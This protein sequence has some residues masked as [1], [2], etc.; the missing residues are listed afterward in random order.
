MS[1]PSRCYFCAQLS[2]LPRRKADRAAKC[3]LCQ[4]EL[5]VRD[6]VSYRPSASNEAAPRRA[7][8]LFAGV[9][10]AVCAVASAALIYP[11]VLPRQEGGESP[12]PPRP[13]QPATP[14]P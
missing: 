4:E 14:R 7:G 1:L 12:Q 13:A 5:L 8:R 11:P 6:G 10:L 2:P 9:V 3:P